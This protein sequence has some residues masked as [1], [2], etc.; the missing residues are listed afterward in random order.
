M[1]S[2]ANASPLQNGDMVINREFSYQ[3]EMNPSSSVSGGNESMIHGMIQQEP[4][5]QSDDFGS[6]GRLGSNFS[7]QM[8]MVRLADITGSSNAG[9]GCTRFRDSELVNQVEELEKKLFGHPMHKVQDVDQI[10]SFE[11]KAEANH[12]IQHLKAKMRD[13]YS[14]L[15]TMQE[16]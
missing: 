1:F 6:N 8:K 16:G 13:L 3:N 4:M 5:A 9:H 7:P 10:K 15:K 11:R 12:G 14:S 2:L